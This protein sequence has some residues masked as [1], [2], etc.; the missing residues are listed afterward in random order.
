MHTHNYGPN[1]KEYTF[2]DNMWNIRPV[3]CV[4]N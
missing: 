2:T 1:L 3:S 4:W